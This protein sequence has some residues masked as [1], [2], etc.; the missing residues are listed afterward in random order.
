MRFV[1]D[2][3]RETALKWWRS[4]TMAE[5]FRYATKFHK[6]KPYEFVSSSSMLI[7]NIYKNV[8][9]GQRT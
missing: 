4:L 9:N 5:R 2:T 7:E 8:T 6:D 1:N 3:T